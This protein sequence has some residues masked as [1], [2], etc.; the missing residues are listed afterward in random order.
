[1]SKQAEILNP[2]EF[3]RLLKIVSTS[4]Y[5]KRDTL[6]ILMSFGLGLRSVELSAL[7]INQV[8]DEN[9]KVRESLNLIRTKGNKKRTLYICDERI[10][11]AIVEY[12]QERKILSAKK[13]LV[14]SLNHPL[15][16][17]QKNSSFTNKTLA[18]RFEI[19]YKECGFDGVTSHS[20]RRTFATNLIEKGID[21]KAVS[22]LM[23]HSHI[24]MTVQYVQNNPIRLKKICSEAL[25]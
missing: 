13:R 17:S 14:F 18:K 16:L 10:K 11:K 7:K 15:F 22:T 25:Y 21:I 23:G 12:V 19:I 3:K 6:L 5:A 24:S 20:G 9:E 2:S 4:R 8:I 1:M